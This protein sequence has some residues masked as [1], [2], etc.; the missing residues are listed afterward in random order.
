MKYRRLGQYGMRVSEVSLGAWT[1]F[2]GS[3]DDSQA[4]EIIHK[5]LELGVNFIDN[6]DVYSRGQAETVVGEALAGD[7]YDRKNLVLSSKVFWPYSDTPNDSGLSRKHIMDSI[8]GTLDRYDQDYIDIYYCH[9][10]DWRTPLRETIETMDDLVRDGLIRYW[11][12]SVW[13]AANLERAIGIAKEIGAR[14]PA[15]EQPRY[16]MLDRYI[17]LEV[18]ETTAYHGMGITPWSPLQYGILSGKYNNDIPEGSRLANNERFQDNLTDEVLEKV[19]KLTALA[20]E[21]DMSMAQ[22]ALA[23]ILRRD[24]IS[25]VIT[26]AT[27]LSHIESNV[28]ASEVTLSQDTLDQIEEIL[29]NKPEMHGPYQPALADRS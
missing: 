19:K 5:A 21:H 24:E 2:G 17:E 3:V 8:H 9:R 27:K 18:M 15:V 14:L 10:F 7:T 16:N 13:S 6:A 12:T 25:S 28:E 11:G 1:T 22:L 23:W 26:G 20:G 4:H 29:D